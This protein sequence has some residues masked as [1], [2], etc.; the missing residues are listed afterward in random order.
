MD[1]GAKKKTLQFTCENEKPMP[2]PVDLNSTVVNDLNA[3]SES[4]LKQSDDQGDSKEFEMIY[5]FD[6]MLQ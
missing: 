6:R 1:I 2:L 4:V 3:P 5:V